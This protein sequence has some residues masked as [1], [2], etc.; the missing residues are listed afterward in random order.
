MGLA[1]GLGAYFEQEMP[2]FQRRII[3]IAISNGDTVKTEL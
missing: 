3:T 2:V 1:E